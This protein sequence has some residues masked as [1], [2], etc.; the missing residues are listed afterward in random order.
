MTF[1][2]ACPEIPVANLTAA[3]VHY[4]NRLGF[5]V[6]WS[7]ED[8][9]LAGLSRGEARLFMASEDYRSGLGNAGPILLWINLNSRDEV[10]ALHAEWA[11]AGADIAAAP[12]ARP[13]KLYE[14]IARD[15]DGNLLRVFYDFGSEER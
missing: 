5:T 14:F 2:P 8:I 11:A 10:D 13:Y 7:D 6:D 1:P 12:E 4:R 3:L 15:L 9:G